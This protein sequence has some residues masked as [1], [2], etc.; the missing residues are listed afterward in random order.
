M[1]YYA[2]IGSRK[3]PV[4]VL[5]DMGRIATILEGRGYVLRSG[6]ADGADSAFE[7]GVVEAKHKGIYLPWKGFN[8]N[9]S[10]LYDCYTDRHEGLA[11]EHHPAWESLSPGVRKLMIR[12]SAQI[13]GAQPPVVL[14][15]SDITDEELQALKDEI[16][17]SWSDPHYAVVSECEFELLEPQIDFVVCGTLAGPEGGGTGQAIRI[18][19]SFDIPVYNLKDMT[20]SEVLKAARATSEE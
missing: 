20:M 1:K 4:L 17:K 6:G 2:G 19:K 13:M 7:K 3:T 18:A 5:R 10:A 16:E 9:P 14:T 8:D 12:N 15:A 11:R